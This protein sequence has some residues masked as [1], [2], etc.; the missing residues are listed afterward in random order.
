LR[1]RAK[2]T[3]SFD[4]KIRTDDQSRT[5]SRFRLPKK[6]RI[7]AFAVFAV[8]AVCIAWVLTAGAVSY[9]KIVDRTG[10]DKAPALSFLGGVKPNQLKGEGDGRVNILLIGVG[11][12]NHP[13]GTLADTIIV[14]SL[15]PKN[16]EVAL[17]SVPRDLYITYDNGKREGK[18]NSVNSYGDQ[19]PKTT[20]GGPALMKQTVSQIL[21][22][23]IHYYVKIDFMAL[24]KII[25]TLGGI[26]VTVDNAIVD[27]Q[28]PADN[29]ID[30]APFRLA[31]GQQKLDGK[32]ALKYVR[33]RHGANGEG[34]DFA[35][36]K[37]QQKV[38]A[39]LK[40]KALSVGVLTSPKKITDI[41]GILGDHV[42]TD[43][44]A[45]EAE[46]F[47]QIV[48]DVDSNKMT[49]TVI[50]NG[51]N[52]PLISH[53]GDA[54]GAILLTKTGDY[55]ELQAIAN[56]VFLDPYL[57]EEKAEVAIINASGSTATGQYV[58]S[59]LK[60][61]G[62]KVTDV[63]TKSQAKQEKTTIIDHTKDNPYTRTFLENRFKVTVTDA[64][65]TSSATDSYDMTITIGT[66]YKPPTVKPSIT[67]KSSVTPTAKVTPSPSPKTSEGTSDAATSD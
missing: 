53:S 56:E 2:P 9:N 65:S 14:A 30:F 60:S 26:T 64:K 1:D 25:D 27:L 62:Y 46:R 59:L 48:K 51:V 58:I 6:V 44:S 18:I 57:R 38:L 50:D 4:K 19:N 28:Y 32:T 40:E 63:T 13:G 21:D 67:V 16:K 36:A 17:L 55:S 34:S 66:S 7:A 49:S 24:Q 39:A 22:I 54:R 37:R 20:G 5:R 52:G 8:A 23:P 42:K 61:R 15:D 41:I 33:S 3:V 31:A 11:G 35:R 47:F 43:I 12:S 10:G 45:V 29:M